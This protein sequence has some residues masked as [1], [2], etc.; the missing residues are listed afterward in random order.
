LRSGLLDYVDGVE[1]VQGY[2]QYF[3]EMI[4]LQHCHACYE[5]LNSLS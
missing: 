5:L 2:E 4:L 1:T 3:P